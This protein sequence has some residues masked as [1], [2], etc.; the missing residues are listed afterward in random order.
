L[1]I[2]A[3]DSV[4]ELT[5]CHGKNL[6]IWA[7][8][9]IGPILQGGQRLVIRSSQWQ[10]HFVINEHAGFVDALREKLGWTGKPKLN[11]RPKPC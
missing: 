2:P 10:S 7:D 3:D 6:R 9:R 4:I 5:E 11:Q 1:V 8:G